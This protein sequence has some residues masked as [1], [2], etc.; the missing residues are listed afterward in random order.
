MEWA[1]GDFDNDG[2]NDVYLS[3]VTNEGL[4]ENDGAGV[5]TDI[6]S[7]AGISITD[8][9]GAAWG[10][11][12]NDG[13]LDLVVAQAGGVSHLYLNR[14]DDTFS[15][16]ASKANIG[17][18]GDLGK[19]VGFF[20]SDNDGDLDIV[21]NNPANLWRNNLDNN[22][23]LKVMAFGNG[24]VG[25]PFNGSAITPT[26][27]QITVRGLDGFFAYREIVPSQNQLAPPHIQHI[28]GVDPNGAYNVE[29]LFPS[30]VKLTYVNVIPSKLATSN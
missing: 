29:V 16:V 1:W 26:G 30:Q 5:F 27:T 13:Y 17:T 18:S 6:T 15:E 9:D 14:G 8:P 28:G 21:T 3:G 20:D 23:Y 2:D 7:S 22:N 4:Y 24:T 12:N 11:F 25:G 10:D 19:T